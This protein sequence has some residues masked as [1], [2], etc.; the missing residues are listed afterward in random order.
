MLFLDF[1]KLTS[2]YILK[3]IDIN[4]YSIVLGKIF[5]LLPKRHHGRYFSFIKHVFFVLIVQL[6]RVDEKYNQLLGIKFLINGRLKGKLMA[7]S[8]LIQKGRIPTQSL[9]KKI[10][11]ASI[12]IFTS[13]LGVFGLKIWVYEK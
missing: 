10:Q 6:K 13:S 11:Y 4:S 12:P 7:S 3:K 2:S 5:R 8:V 1:L 9:E